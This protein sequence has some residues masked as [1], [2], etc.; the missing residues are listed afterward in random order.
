MWY[1]HIGES[2]SAKKWEFTTN[3]HTS[4]SVNLKCI[5]LSEGSQTQKSIYSVNSFIGYSGKDRIIEIENRSGIS[6]RLAMGD[7][8][9]ARGNFGG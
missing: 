2:Y 4:T 6:Q 9:A 7:R 1:V 8:T 5:R 3:T